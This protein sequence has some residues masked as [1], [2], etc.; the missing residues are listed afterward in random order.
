MSELWVVGLVAVLAGATAAIA[1]AGIGSMLTPLVAL[2]ADFQAAVVVVAVPHLVGAALRVARLWRDVDWKTVRTFG[3]SCALGALAGV[4]LSSAI[5]SAWLTRTFAVLLVLAGVLAL[6]GAER[7]LKPGKRSSLAV[8][9]LAGLTGGLVG[10]QGGIRA[11]GLLGFHLRRDAFAATSA[12]V[13]V[14]IDV[15]RT[16]VYLATRWSEVSSH[17]NVMAVATAGVV[18]GTGLGLVLL[19]RIPE[20]LFSKAVA[21]IVIVLGVLLLFRPTS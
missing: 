1:G 18:V 11:V 12:A 20:A 21:V 8:G 19:R 16:P 14:V 5:A 7:R 3:L 2:H 4:A 15:V 10:E 6:A 9:A 13:A 17:W